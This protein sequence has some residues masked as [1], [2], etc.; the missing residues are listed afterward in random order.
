MLASIIVFLS[1]VSCA[2]RTD[3]VA[4]PDGLYTLTRQGEDAW[5]QMA[6]IRAAILVEGNQYCETKQM[7]MKVVQVKEIPTGAFNKAPRVDI[8]FRCQPLVK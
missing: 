1:L 8:L 4:T 2:S 7:A 3:V 6:D 5:V